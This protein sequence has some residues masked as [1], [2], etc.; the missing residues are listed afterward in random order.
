MTVTLALTERQVAPGAPMQ[1]SASVNGTDN[2][3]DSFPNTRIGVTTTIGAPATFAAFAHT[4]V[5]EVDSAIWDTA[6]DT[7]G[8]LNYSGGVDIPTPGTRRMSVLHR[9]DGNY[10]A[11]RYLWFSGWASS[12]PSSGDAPTQIAGPA[13]I[14]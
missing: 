5:A 13:L 14:R 2:F 6:T 10:S 3:V 8:V 1:I 12:T 11:G 9:L 7:A 4:D